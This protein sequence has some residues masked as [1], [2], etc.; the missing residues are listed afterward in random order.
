MEKTH[1]IE[2]D[3]IKRS[4]EGPVSFLLSNE[5]GGFFS[6]PVEG[7]ILSKFQGAVSCDPSDVG[8]SLFKNIENISHDLKIKNVVNKLWCVERFSDSSMERFFMPYFYNAVVYETEG[9]KEAKLSLDVRGIHDFHRF[10]RFY[11]IYDED[12]F[13]VIEYTKHEER[14]EDNVHG[15]CYKLFLVIASDDISIKKKEEWVETVYAY[16][17]F[18]GSNPSNWWVYD[19]LSLKLKNKSAV[20]F[21]YSHDKE[22][23]MSLASYVKRNL[24]VLKNAQKK[25][26]DGVVSTDLKIDN[27][28]VRIAYKCTLKALDDLS[29]TIGGKHGVYAGLWWFFQ[30]WSRDEAQSIK[31]LALQRKFDECKEILFR[32][33]QIIL[34]DGRIPNRYPHTLLGSADGVG[35]TFKRFDDLMKMLMKLNKFDAYFS[36]ADVLAVQEKLELA[37]TKIRRHH[38]DSKGFV[39]NQ[40]LETWMDTAHSQVKDV[41]AGVRVEI[42]ALTLSM[43]HFMQDLARLTKNHTQF[44]KYQEI[45]QDF[46][47]K[48]KE[49]LWTGSYLADGFD[50]NK[51]DDT[52]R[53]NVFIAAYV[54]PDLL[55]RDEWIKCFD[56]VLPRLWCDW[57]EQGGGLATIDKQSEL[58]HDCYSGENPESYHRGDSWYHLNCLAAIAMHRIDPERYKRYIDSILRSAT[59]AILYSGVIGHLAELSS[60]KRFESNGCPAQAWAEAF[61][62]ELVNELYEKK[63]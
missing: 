12:G 8:W 14:T 41:R 50:N 49:L 16:D 45:E 17:K 52:V 21:S 37:I 18:R 31:G 55:S 34:P 56:T 35:W 23:A 4:V 51:R 9:L 48:V 29:V 30:W 27:P 43:Y 57:G 40:D 44:K 60:A 32:E 25:Y 10:G 33:I 47:K 62:I 7:K 6:I 24:T 42:Q 26:V 59:F 58:F 3:V 2:T 11:N 63:A 39:T 22:K 54:Y 1:I 20:V 5:I 15:K 19:A 61:Y 53:P 28:E 36:I 38:M 46:L 13:I